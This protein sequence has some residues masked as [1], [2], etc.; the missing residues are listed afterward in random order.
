MERNHA[1]AIKRASGDVEEDKGG[2]ATNATIVPST[3]KSKHKQGKHDM[4]C[5]ADFSFDG[6]YVLPTFASV[7]THGTSKTELLI[8]TP[9][10]SLCKDDL[11][12]KRHADNSCI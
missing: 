5:K 9:C 11:N 6:Q 4:D 2:N 8:S 1:L 12:Y 10:V 3:S 7:L